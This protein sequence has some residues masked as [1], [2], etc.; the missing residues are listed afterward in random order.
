MNPEKLTHDDIMNIITANVK[1]MTMNEIQIMISEY[2]MTLL[3]AKQKLLISDEKQKEEKL[4]M[5]SSQIVVL[6][7]LKARIKKTA[8]ELEEE[9]KEVRG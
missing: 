6:E 3:D 1:I 2:M 4:F 5:L 8:D 7:D 9:V